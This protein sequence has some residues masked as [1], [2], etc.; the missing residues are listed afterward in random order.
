MLGQR[1]PGSVPSGLSLLGMFTQGCALLALGYHL[2]PFQG[3]Q[4]IADKQSTL[5]LTLDLNFA[6]SGIRV[7][8]SV[9]C[10]WHNGLM[11]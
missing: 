10:I 3:L 5:K 11:T 9:R 8:L 1:N 7:N 2:K 6:S 4:L